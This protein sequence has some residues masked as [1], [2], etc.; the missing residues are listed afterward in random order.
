MKYVPAIVI[1]GA[2]LITWVLNI[3]LPSA[4]G[5]AAAVGVLLVPALIALKVRP[6]MAASAVFA[7]TW[8]SVVSPGLMFNPQIADI[9]FKAK[10]IGAPDAMIVIMQEF[11]PCAIGALVVAAVLAL[12]CM[13]LKEG[14][15]SYSVVFRRRRFRRSDWQKKPRR[16]SL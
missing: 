6:V 8:G 3:V 7:G 2:V 1:P 15:G 16:I 11:L 10:E 12:I 13:F 4:A 14:V 5:I 9:A